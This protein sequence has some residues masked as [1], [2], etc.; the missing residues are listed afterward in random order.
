MMSDARR[1]VLSQLRGACEND[2]IVKFLFDNIRNIGLAGVVAAAA[3]WYI[4][5]AT[6]LYALIVGMALA[7]VAL[8]LFFIIIVNFS[9]KLR[10]LDVSLLIKIFV[11]LLYGSVVAALLSYLASH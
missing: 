4:R 3:D 10:A 1:S 11:A 8:V 5:S 9:S 7:L 2:D 6:G